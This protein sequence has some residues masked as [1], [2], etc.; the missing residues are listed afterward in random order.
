MCMDT[1]IS[2]ELSVLAGA[3]AGPISAAA[4]MAFFSCY[5]DGAEEGS[6]L[7]QVVN[8]VVSNGYGSGCG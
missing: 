1:I 4:T 2:P 7:V 3:D 8:F 5:S 6:C